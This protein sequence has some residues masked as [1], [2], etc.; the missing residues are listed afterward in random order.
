MR[1]MS[2]STTLE[3]AIKMLDVKS[4]T[5]S[6]TLSEAIR[7]IK[8][9]YGDVTTKEVGRGLYRFYFKDKEVGYYKGDP[10]SRKGLLTV[11]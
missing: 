1:D 4:G 3:K 5:H 9:E 6:S 11:Y 8:N 10:T 7:Y 2:T